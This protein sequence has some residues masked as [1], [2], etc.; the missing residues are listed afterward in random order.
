MSV[1]LLRSQGKYGLHVEWLHH[2]TVCT[3]RTRRAWLD[4]TMSRSLRSSRR[5]GAFGM[6][7]LLVLSIPIL[8]G[9]PSGAT[10]SQTS[11]QSASSTI[12]TPTSGPL[13][14]SP[15]PTPTPTDHDHHHNM[16]HT[17]DGYGYDTPS[18]SP[19]PSP[20]PTFGERPTTE[21]EPTSRLTGTAA[22]AT[23]TSDGGTTQS[24]PTTPTSSETATRPGSNSAGSGAT[25]TTDT[26]PNNPL[27]DL[28][29]GV[30]ASISVL[31]D[32]IGD[33]LA[34]LLP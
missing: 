8:F 1:V 12:P 18:S 24:T 10:P 21:D 7:A 27:T 33:A 17:D 20:S 11:V 16:T 22:T 34:G 14:P 5:A 13:A 29:K 9:P 19:S 2:G 6:T 31:T 15:T 32:W 28:L 26:G 23:P 4:G 3:A 25:E 30:R